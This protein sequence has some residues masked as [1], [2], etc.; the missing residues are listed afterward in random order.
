[1]FPPLTTCQ[2][3]HPNTGSPTGPITS[4]HTT[5]TTHNATS[6][7]AGLAACIVPLSRLFAI[8]AIY[9]PGDRPY[10]QPSVELGT[11]RSSCT[12]TTL[13]AVVS[14]TIIKT[15]RC[16]RLI[17]RS[18]GKSATPLPNTFRSSGQEPTHYWCTSNLLWLITICIC[19][20]LLRPWLYYRR[21]R[22]D[23]I[24]DA[25]RICGVSWS[26]F[27]LRCKDHIVAIYLS[28]WLYSATFGS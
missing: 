23:L 18:S 11:G 10:R 20:L 27:I 16:S 8:V 17:L 15:A 26:R 22:S 6:N 25:M 1:M 24:A 13:V 7:V 19:G 12:S 2:K 9:A 14:Q 4:F 3:W 5:S 21:L 28:P